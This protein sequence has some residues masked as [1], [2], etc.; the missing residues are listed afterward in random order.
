[1]TRRS[2]L[3]LAVCLLAGCVGYRLTESRPTTLAVPGTPP[4]GLAKI[5]VVRPQSRVLSYTAIVR[6]NGHLVGGTEGESFFCYLAAPGTHRMVTQTGRISEDATVYAEPAGVYTLR[7]RVD[8]GLDNLRIS[9]E[10][11]DPDLAIEEARGLRA[12]TLAGAPA[13]E[14]LP[15]LGAVLPAAE[16]TRSQARV[17]GGAG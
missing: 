15:R 6:D 13:A 14:Q 16:T 17:S 9:Q 8:Y 12:L 1:M 2:P 3:T 7:Q 10:W 11:I 5:C 4:A